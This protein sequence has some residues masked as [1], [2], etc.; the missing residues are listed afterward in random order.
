MFVCVCV[1]VT[2]PESVAQLVH[3]TKYEPT[4]VSVKEGRL[5]YLMPSH[6]IERILGEL[7]ATNICEFSAHVVGK[8]ESG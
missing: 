8:A 7:A 1:H 5:G 3:A 6:Q 4:F 2:P